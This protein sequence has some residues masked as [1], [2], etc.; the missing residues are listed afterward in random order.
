MRFLR[1]A[2]ITLLV[3]FVVVAV[4]GYVRVRGGGLSAEAE[5]TRL[6]SSVARRLVKLSIPSDAR[7]RSN[8]MPSESWR[9]ALDHYD[10]HC[11]VCHGDDGRGHTQVGEN[12]Y[13]KVPDLTSA[14]IQQMTDGELFSVIQ[15]GVRWTGMP[16]WKSEHSE[17][18]TWKLVALVRRTPSL[19]E[20][21]LKQLRAKPETSTDMKTPDP[22]HDND[23]HPHQHGR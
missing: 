12:M 22:K 18:E 20:A 11:A 19:T 23:K 7:N 3:F 15:N 5:P 6:E 4:V 8:P 14:T 2:V 17:E 10:D 9:D 21:E 1:D 13:P 16:A